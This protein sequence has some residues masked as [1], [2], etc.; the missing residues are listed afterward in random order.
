MTVD[1]LRAASLF[2]AGRITFG[3]AAAA[4][5]EPSAESA[6]WPTVAGLVGALCV[7]GLLRGEH[8]STDVFAAVVAA[9]TSALCAY[10]AAVAWLAYAAARRE[11]FAAVAAVEAALRNPNA[12]EPRR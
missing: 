11:H 4:T 12:T 7:A 5:S 6:A 2:A 3:E 8:N 10:N 1:P 9:L